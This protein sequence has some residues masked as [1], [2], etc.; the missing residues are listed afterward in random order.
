MSELYAS[1]LMIGV[2]LSFGG[3]VVSIAAGQFQATTGG[4]SQAAFAQQEQVGKLV[5]LVYGTVVQGSGG[6][7]ATYE[8][9]DG[10]TY[11]EGKSYV[12]AL[13]DYG[14]VSFAPA[15]VFD[16]GTL[17]SA[18]GFSAIAAAQ[19]GQSAGPVANVL[20]LPSCAHPSGQALVLV[21]TSGDE[22]E[23]GT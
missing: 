11:L 14:S 19:P 10:G 22:I 3:A 6:C 13:Y 12:L 8:G 5:T 17:L 4:S 7:T 15:E 2:T 20:T 18:G 23:N 21:D 16:N 1:L 9:P